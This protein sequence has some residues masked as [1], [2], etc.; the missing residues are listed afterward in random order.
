MKGKL[1]EGNRKNTYL[2][3]SKNEFNKNTSNLIKGTTEVM[4]TLPLL[5]ATV[6]MIGG[7]SH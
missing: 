5:G 7:L 6:G 2:K 4:V 1:L 3:H